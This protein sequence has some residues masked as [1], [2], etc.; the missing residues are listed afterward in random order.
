MSFP[1]KDIICDICRAG[2][3]QNCKPCSHLDKARI[4]ELAREFIKFERSQTAES[5]LCSNL[6]IWVDEPRFWE[7]C[8]DFDAK[9][10]RHQPIWIRKIYQRKIKTQI[11]K[12]VS[13][14]TNS[15]SKMLK[16]LRKNFENFENS[17]T[18]EYEAEVVRQDIE[19]FITLIK[20]KTHFQVNL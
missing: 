19:H 16:I 12:I 6:D 14:I 15:N 1:V 9:L 3:D 13:N 10:Q 7:S 20:N 2:L 5:G 17:A 4:E 18:D 8:L 11:S